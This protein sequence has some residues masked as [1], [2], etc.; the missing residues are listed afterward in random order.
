MPVE[1]FVINLCL[2]SSSIVIILVFLRLKLTL[3]VSGI[4]SFGNGKA[5]LAKRVHHAFLV[6]NSTEKDFS[7]LSQC[8]RN[9]SNPPVT[10]ELMYHNLRKYFI[11][12]NHNLYLNVL[13]LSTCSTYK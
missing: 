8:S 2:D 11:H 6:I 7:T 5:Y 3:Y 9:Q 12:W 4:M 13:N 10:F 1:I